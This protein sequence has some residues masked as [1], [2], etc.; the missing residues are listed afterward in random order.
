MG[1]KKI[2]KLSKEEYCLLVDQ[3]KKYVCKKCKRK[4][5]DKKKLCSGKKIKE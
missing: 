4:S 3:E 2:C 5:C 1:K